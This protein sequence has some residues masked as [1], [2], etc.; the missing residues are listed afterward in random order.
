V[1]PLNESDHGAEPI[2][3][4]TEAAPGAGVYSIPRAE[5]RRRSLAGIFYLTSSSV[6]NLLTGFVA[7]LVL[8]R[9]LTPNDFG[10]V[11]IGSTVILIATA[12]ADGGLG[13][14]MVRRPEA[15]TQAELRTMNGIQLALTC[16]I[17]LPA[18]VVALFFGR[19][20]AITAV[21]IISLPIMMLQT[22]GRIVLTRDMRYDRQLAIDFGSQASSQIFAVVAVI[23]GAGVWGLA[24][25]AI[26]KAVVGTA[27]TGAMSIGLQMPSLR[28]WRSYGGLIRFGLSF[29]A[30]W[31][32]FVARE[33]GL[34]IVI[35]A[36]AGVT[37]LG[38]WTFTN[39]IFQLPLVAFSSLYV[40]GFPAMSNLLARGE[41]PGPIIL[42]TVRRAAIAG[43]FIFPL[44]A[45]SSPELIPSVFGEQWRDAASIVPFI[46]LSTL[47]LG[48]INVAAT[49]Y[50]AASGRPGL[51]VWSTASLG[52]VWLGVTAALLPAIGVTAIGAGNLGGALVETAILTVATRRTA[53]VYPHRPLLRPLGVALVAGT[54]GWV[55]CVSG[56]S[57]LWI[58]I[59]SGALTIALCAI[60]LWAVCRKDLDETIRLITGTMQS[61][62]P[63]PPR[64]RRPSTEG[65]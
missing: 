32:M 57:G 7:S 15:P 17:C 18:F 41:D 20:G 26:V 1:N 52:V 64:L 31:F 50:L 24:F 39:R 44:F 10:V 36:V 22:P 35:A 30:S 59:A 14:G 2:T 62:V 54:L 8:A 42:R 43:T 25:A 9:L 55:L 37:T 48:S 28:G 3:P 49:S 51:L 38:L 19:T 11:A 13:A 56:P 53:G 21:M 61:V 4:D 34:N 12:L 63:R 60:G 16:A 45:A 5:V 47:I 29:Q 23:L 27:L 65:A 40:V 6:A 58:A 46:C 33:Q